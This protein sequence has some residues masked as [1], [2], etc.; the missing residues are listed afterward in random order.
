MKIDDEEFESMALY[1]NK[2]MQHSIL[3][4]EFIFKT[5]RSDL[6]VNF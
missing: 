4:N 2:T 5:P 3:K 1:K 6:D